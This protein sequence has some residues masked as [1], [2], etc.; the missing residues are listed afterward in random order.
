MNIWEA[1]SQP[2][3]DDDPERA[4]LNSSRHYINYITNMPATKWL[5]LLQ[6]K[7]EL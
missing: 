7:R 5:H 2:K 1:T 4:T 3:R 6:R